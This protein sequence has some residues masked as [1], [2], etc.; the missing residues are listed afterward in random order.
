MAVLSD[1]ASMGSCMK[2]RLMSPT[3]LG[4]EFIVPIFALA[5]SSVIAFRATLLQQKLEEENNE[6]LLIFFNE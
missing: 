5:G 4:T 3:Y 2:M 6:V 1:G